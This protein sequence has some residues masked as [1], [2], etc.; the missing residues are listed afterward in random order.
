MR[1]LVKYARGVGKLA[2]RDVVEPSIAPN[3]VLVQ[4]DACGVCGTDL[5]IQDDKFIY[6]PPVTVGHEFSG[7]IVTVGTGVSRWKAGDRVVAEQH[8]EACGTCEYCLTG[9]RHFCLKKRS[10]GYLS[11]GA[12]AE[13]IAVDAAL[14]H[15]IPDAVSLE[16]AALVEPMAVAAYGIL[17]RTGIH[18]EDRVVILGCG[19]IAVLALQLLRAAGASRVIL[20]GL[21]SDEAA[22]FAVARRL[23]ADAVINVEREDPVAVVKEMT[24]GAGVDVVVDLTGAAPAIRQGF[25]MVRRDGRFCALGMPGGDVPLPWTQVALQAIKVIFSFSSHYRSWEL[26]LSMIENGRVDLS[27]FTADRFSLDSWETAYDKAR[28]GETLKSLILPQMKGS[29]S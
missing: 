13:R 11:N 25:E 18:P 10:P 6:D 19:P 8:F 21:S 15:R 29:A 24:D 28:G 9:R 7:T 12:F 17:E 3:Q 20:T 26:C 4:V 14:L 5:K 16:A 22:R 1:A 27:D 23:G 2:V